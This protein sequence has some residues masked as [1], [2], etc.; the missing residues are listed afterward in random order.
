MRDMDK[1]LGDGGMPLLGLLGCTITAYGEHFAEGTW[2]PTEIACNPGGTI[3]AG[4]SSVVLDAI[5]NFALLAS[6]ERG[7]NVATIEM[8]ASTMRVG[9]AGDDLAVRGEV[10]RLGNR[11]GYAQAFVRKGD[12]AVVHATGSFVVFRREQ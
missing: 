11:V 7:E 2:K 1:W 3:Q 12:D 10:L 4:V 5:M 8:K 9:R 6:L